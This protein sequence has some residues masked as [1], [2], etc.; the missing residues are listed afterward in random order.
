MKLLVKAVAAGFGGGLLMVITMNAPTGATNVAAPILAASAQRNDAIASFTFHAD[1]A[2]RM[3]HF[4]WLHFHMQGYGDYQRGD[5]YVVHLTG[6]MFASKVHQIDLSMID[7]AL[8]PGRY[9]HT[10]IAQRDGDTLFSL[11]AIQDPSLQSATVALSPIYGPQWVDATYS[12]GM[13]IHMVVSSNNVDGFLLPVALTA[14]VDYPHMPLVA[15]ADFTD[16]SINAMA[17]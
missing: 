7:P 10:I 9:R 8:W 5:H 2:M 11:Q 6:G 17:H 16:Y 3:Q 14:D 13:H 15:D 12:Q 1:I 4:P